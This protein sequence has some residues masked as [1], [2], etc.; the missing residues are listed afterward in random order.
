MHTLSTSIIIEA[1]IAAI[2]E[3]NACLAAIFLSQQQL[4]NAPSLDE[5]D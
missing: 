4:P 3:F 2:V 1:S 5:K